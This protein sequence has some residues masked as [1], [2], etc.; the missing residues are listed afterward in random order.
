M[1]QGL[2]LLSGMWHLPRPKF[3]SMSSELAGRF[4]STVPRG[5]FQNKLLNAKSITIIHSALSHKKMLKPKIN[6]NQ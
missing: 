5:K 6:T 2:Q 4:L 1:L 3:E